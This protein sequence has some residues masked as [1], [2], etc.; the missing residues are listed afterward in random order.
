MC[1][2]AAGVLG[3]RMTRML[4]FAAFCLAGL[5]TAVAIRAAMPMHSSVAKSTQAQGTPWSAFTL[6]ETAKSDRLE[7]PVARME[8]EAPTMSMPAGAPLMSPEEALSIGPQPATADAIPD[9]REA[10]AKAVSAAPSGRPPKSKK[11]KRS[12]TEHEKRPTERTANEKPRVAFHCRQDAVGGLLRSLDLS[13]QCD[14]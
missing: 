1:S 10:N 12:L 6:N 2:R 14:L 13:P 8:I 11:L 4:W 9:W 3:S 7:L 5:G